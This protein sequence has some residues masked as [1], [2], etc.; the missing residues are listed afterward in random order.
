MVLHFYSKLTL[1]DNERLIPVT[2]V[3]INMNR[4]HNK[5]LVAKINSY[6]TIQNSY[7]NV[8]SSKQKYATIVLQIFFNALF[9]ITHW[10]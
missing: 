5:N 6:L 10:G 1:K 7:P 3:L 9:K 2:N 4:I 8:I